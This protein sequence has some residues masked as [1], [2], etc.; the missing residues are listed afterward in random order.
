MIEATE[1]SHSGELAL[2]GAPVSHQPPRDRQ[3]DAG[4][5]RTGTELLC[6]HGGGVPGYAWIVAS[7]T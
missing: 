6:R 7:V 5:R 3:T 4:L 1:E 2:M